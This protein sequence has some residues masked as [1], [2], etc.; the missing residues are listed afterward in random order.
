MNPK[1]MILRIFIIYN[2]N[3]VILKKEQVFTL[4]T[5]MLIP[6]AQT[7][8]IAQGISQFFWGTVGGL[9]TG[10]AAYHGTK[11]LGGNEETAQLMNLLGNFVG[12]YKFSKIAENFSLNTIRVPKVTNKNVQS[13]SNLDRVLKLDSNTALEIKNIVEA[14]GLSLEEFSDLLIPEKVLTFEQEQLV[15]KVRETIGIPKAGTWMTKV[16]PIENVD[17]I[18]KGEWKS[19]RGFLS[20]KKHSDSLTKLNEVYNGN[21]LDYHNSPFNPKTTKTYAKIQFKLNETDM[22]DIPYE[23]DLKGNYPFTGRGFTGAKDI[24][25]PEY[26]LMKERMFYSGDTI[27]IFNSQTGKILE[28]YEFINEQGWLLVK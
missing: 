4:T 22:I 23:G 21:R 17:L 1:L 15:R 25:L 8:S 24:I 9:A 26:K 10:Q 18:I 20:V 19:I 27:T 3:K 16:I 28:I 14:E 11:L 7:Q 13:S 2:K 12:G 5:G 6:I